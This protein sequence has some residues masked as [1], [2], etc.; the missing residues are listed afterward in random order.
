MY[1]HNS[2][3][4]TPV[5][6]TQRGGEGRAGRREQRTSTGSTGNATPGRH[7]RARSAGQPIPHSTP[8]SGFRAL[9][10]SGDRPGTRASRTQVQPRPLPS[11]PAV[12][13]STVPHQIAATR[14][15]SLPTSGSRS[16][17]SPRGTTA[18]G[19]AAPA[20]DKKLLRQPDGRGGE[21][22]QA[23]AE[24]GK[25]YYW[26]SRTREVQWKKPPGWKDE[27]DL[28]PTPNGGSV[29]P[30]KADLAVPPPAKPPVAADE[31]VAGVTTHHASVSPL[32]PQPA[33]PPNG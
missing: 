18:A 13:A 5:P 20:G 7:H 16:R 8:P 14:S 1:Q 23:L 22:R 24:A 27:L 10:I 28:Q 33:S 6:G 26:N 11:S 17:P 2:L 4:L 19:N 21:W 12:T 9:R 31:G 32:R 30:P 15:R 25:I 3:L 29:P